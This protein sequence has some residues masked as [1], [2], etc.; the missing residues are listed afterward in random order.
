[1]KSIVVRNRDQHLLAA[2]GRLAE[3]SLR[4]DSQSLVITQPIFPTAVWLDEAVD[5]S[6]IK[7]ALGSVTIEMSKV[8]IIRDKF[9]LLGI[10]LALTLIVLL[11][12]MWMVRSVSRRTTL[13]IVM[14][15]D[16]VRR[17]GEGELAERISSPTDIEEIQELAVGINQMAEQLQ[18]E[19]RQLEDKV[20]AATLAL[21]QK[22]KEEEEANFN[23]TRFLAA[24]SHDLRQ[25]M[26][27]L[28]LFVGE[29]KNSLTTAE[30]VLVAERI[31]ISVEAMSGLL[32]ALLDVS[33]LD[34]GVMLPY[35]KKF[36]LLDIFDRLARNFSVI[37]A[38]KNIKLRVV[39][40]VVWV[41]SDP[42]LLERMIS[43][44]MSNA[45]K[46]TSR[47]GSILV[48]CR[49]RGDK[50]KI[51]VRDNGVGIDPAEHE[52]VF[53][54]FVQLT[55]P[56]RDRSNGLGLGLA[57]VRRLAVLLGHHIEL[58]SAAGLGST[59]CLWLDQVSAEENNQLPV[60]SGDRRAGERINQ[61]ISGQRVLVV[62]D[63]ILVRESTKGI[64]ESWG[65][66]VTIAESFA[67]AIS[68]CQLNTFDLVVS[69]YR[70][71]DGNGLQLAEYLQ[72]S[73]AKAPKFILISGDAAP[74]ILS[75]VRYNG[76]DLLHKPVRPAKLRSLIMH[77]LSEAD[78]GDK[79]VI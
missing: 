41:Y 72:S 50:L 30:Q 45:V 14:M 43:N 20:Q 34:A 23:K 36:S 26:H 6:S 77:V 2:A 76:L 64:I 44:L 55:N 29:L 52:N 48:A 33:K 39:P 58:K 68:Q 79:L 10:N 13:P 21:R 22:V 8:K 65:C 9:Y 78:D 38:E 42:V 75:E 53:R 57:I 3:Q 15:N 5:S 49:Q 32:E 25:P 47:G 71:P 12:S 46:Y 59:F 24:A 56:G 74:E 28:G 4:D 63:D 18:L 27:A 54:E 17:L 31:A 70:L 7:V 60:D 37:A 51:E 19:R 11:I 40:T 73:V 67:S 16:T 69:D 35:F 61:K 1:V 66:Q 62:D